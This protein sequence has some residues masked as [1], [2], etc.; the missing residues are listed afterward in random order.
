LQNYLCKDIFARVP[1]D[2]DEL[3]VT[4]VRALAH[5]LRLRILDLLR[6]DGPATAT[7]L[8]ARVGESSGSTSYHLRQ[9]AR[10]GFIEEAPKRGGRER[11]W[12]YEERR[13]GIAGNADSPSV[14]TL[15]GELLSR[16][17]YALDRYLSASPRDP[18]W[19]DAAFF[20]TKALMLTASEL[21]EL[22]EVLDEALAGFNAAARDDAPAEALP[23]RFLA[24]GFPQAED[25][26]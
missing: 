18:A 20:Q 14:R 12:R 7:M 1:K 15:L 25:K 6:F 3:D 2:A 10:H 17:S 13:S 11:W 23:V 21:K 22:S 24:F 16:E 4:A 26:P 8:A 9:L 5:P 19:D